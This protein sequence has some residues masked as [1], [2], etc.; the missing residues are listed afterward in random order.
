MAKTAAKTADVEAK[1][2]PVEK[3][4]PKGIAEMILDI[5]TEKYTLIP[6]AS[7]WAKHIRTLEEF[8]GRP[9]SEI[10]DHALRDVLSAKITWD[11]IKKNMKRAPETEPEEEDKKK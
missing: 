2:V 3:A 9:V 4:V 6:L 10:L 1:A 7:V 5:K 11:T 8:R